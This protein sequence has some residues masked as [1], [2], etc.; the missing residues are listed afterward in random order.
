MVDHPQPVGVELAHRVEVAGVDPRP[1]TRADGLGL[2]PAEDRRLGLVGHDRRLGLPRLGPRGAHL[3]LLGGVEV[4]RPRRG[5]PRLARGA[6]GA[7]DLG[8]RHERVG[9]VGQRVGRLGQRDRLARQAHGIVVRA[10]PGERLGAHPAPRDR[11]LEVLAALALRVLGERDRLLVAALGEDRPREQRRRLGRAGLD[12]ERRE[13]VA[14]GAE[15]PLRRAGVT[16]QQLDDPRVD[17]ELVQLERQAELLERGAAVA[18]DRAARLRPPAHRLEHRLAA[19][20]HRL[21]VAVARRHPDDAH[22]VEAAAARADDGRRAPQRGPRRAGEDGGHAAPVAGGARRHQRA[23]ERRFGRGD[24][25]QQRVGARDDVVGLGLT[26]G[27][28]R[29]RPASRRRPAAARWSRA[30]RPRPRGWRAAPRRRSRGRAEPRRRRARS[31]SSSTTSPPRAV[32]PAESSASARSRRTSGWRL[33]DDRERAGE[34]AGGGGEVLAGQ[35]APP[36]LREALAGAAAQRAG[37][38]VQ[39]PQLAPVAV[40]ALEV[41]A[42]ELVL[43]GPAP[44]EPR[45]DALV[46]LGARLLEQRPVRGV[47][48]E[49]VAEAEAVVAERDHELLAPQRVEVDVDVVAAGQLGHR[50]ARELRAR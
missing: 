6:G 33:L 27:V 1:P 49:G 26:R 39:R 3:V 13:A 46:Q 37:L 30:R 41:E 17:V 7:E 21:D 8:E 24:L 2:G 43:L 34:E 50:R 10:A 36:R 29:R 18:Q 11:R 16:G 32:S 48:D 9:L 20:R 28:A 19:Q 40:G 4:A 44:L 35:R 5:L 31:P 38:L 22:D 25:A 12:A 23:V 42:G 14:S 15:V 45:R 47:S